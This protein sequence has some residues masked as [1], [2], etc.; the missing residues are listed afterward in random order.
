MNTREEWFIALQAC[1]RQ[2]VTVVTMY[3][4]LGEEAIC[5]S[6]NETEVTTV[7]CGNKELKNLSI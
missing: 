1:F 3:A 2:N 4:S 6:L 5:H 7:I